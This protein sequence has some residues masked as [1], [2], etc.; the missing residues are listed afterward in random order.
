MSQKFESSDWSTWL[1]EPVEM[2][3]VFVCAFVLTIARKQ[4]QDFVYQVLTNYK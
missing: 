1:L 2:V 3:G 4:V